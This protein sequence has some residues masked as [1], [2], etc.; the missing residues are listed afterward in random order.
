MYSGAKTLCCKTSERRRRER[1]SFQGRP[2]TK[3][4]LSKFYRPCTV[5]NWGLTKFKIQ[6][7]E[8]YYRRSVPGEF[9]PAMLVNE[10]R[11]TLV[12]RLETHE[13]NTAR[14]SIWSLDGS[15]NSICYSNCSGP[16]GLYDVS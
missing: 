5:P 8:A 3:P 9:V 1:T 16:P 4:H 6:S 10:L 7:I 2:S 11:E 12:K 13:A 14:S 15:D